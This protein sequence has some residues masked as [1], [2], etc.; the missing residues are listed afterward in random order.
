MLRLGMR[1]LMVS[2]MRWRY[3]R[4]AYMVGRLGVLVLFSV[5]LLFPQKVN[6]KR[7]LW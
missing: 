2:G 6:K 7:S 5:S 1:N 3:I 4:S